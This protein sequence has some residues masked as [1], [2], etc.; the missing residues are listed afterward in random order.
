M[1][2]RVRTIVFPAPGW[3][4]FVIRIRGESVAQRRIDDYLLDATK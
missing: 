1:H 2:I 3:Y 4:D